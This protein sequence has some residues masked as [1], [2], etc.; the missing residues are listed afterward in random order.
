MKVGLTALRTLLVEYE[1]FTDMYITLHS[2][3]PNLVKM[4]VGCGISHTINK[5]HIKYN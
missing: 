3:D 5:T 4:T 1:V 2:M